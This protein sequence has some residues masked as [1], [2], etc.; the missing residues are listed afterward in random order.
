MITV[1]VMACI[2]WT[3]HG[4]AHGQWAM[5][6]V[7]V[8]GMVMV[9]GIVMDMDMVM[10]MVMYRYRRYWNQFADTDTDPRYR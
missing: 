5:G 4:N 7:I 6:M 2:A 9:M 8:M 3:G 10:V 1:T